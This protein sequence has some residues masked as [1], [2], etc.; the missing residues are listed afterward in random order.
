MSAPLVKSK[1][2]K[3]PFYLAKFKVLVFLVLLIIILPGYFF[4][5]KPEYESYQKNKQLN[6][7]Y[8]SQRDLALNQ[9]KGYKKTLSVYQAVDP[10]EEEKINQILPDN[11][12][13][14]NLYVNLESIVKTVGL[15][16]DNIIINPVTTQVT[17]RPV[18]GKNT[19]AEA[20][21]SNQI[22]L[23][24]IELILSDVSY[25]KMKNFFTV[26]ET[27]IRLLDVKQFN[28]NAVDGT[29]S[30]SLQAYYLKSDT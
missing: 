7:Q 17:R 19:E 14:A 20:A 9:L 13:E 15:S 12:D 11:Y 27:N 30:V 25:V 6:A 16:L 23:I 24:D 4:F 1:Q 18:I 26:L 21:L 5:V 29:L 10:L 3:Q 2:P 28:F 8:Q 22:G